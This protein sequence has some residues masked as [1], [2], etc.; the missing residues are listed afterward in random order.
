MTD[1]GTF[2]AQ[3]T[4]KLR[5]RS[6]K[7]LAQNIGRLGSSLLAADEDEPEGDS[8]ELAAPLEQ[9]MET[10]EKSLS[11]VSGDVTKIL[12]ALQSMK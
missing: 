9:R 7:K 1:A 10:M 6:T 12:Q 5:R 2:C 3:A 4:R 8:A 11:S